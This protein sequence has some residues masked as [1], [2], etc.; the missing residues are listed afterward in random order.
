MDTRKITVFYDGACPRCLRELA[1]Y[2]RFDSRHR[3]E[4]FNLVGNEARVQAFG[5]DPGQ[6]L[7]KLHIRMPDGSIV[8]DIDAF[9]V[10]WREVPLF[11]PLAACFAIPG[12]KSVVE[13]LYQAVT[14]RRLRRQGRLCDD[15]CEIQELEK[16]AD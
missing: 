13:T 6:T 3:V 4:W 1:L 15:R 14:L 16:P 5:I 2:R 9:I 7:K 8:K 11:R 12:L 10:L